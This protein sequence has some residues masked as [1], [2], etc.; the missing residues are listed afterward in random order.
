MARFVLICIS[1]MTKNVEHFF[2]LSNFVQPLKILQVKIFY[3]WTPFLI[4][5]FDSLESNFLNSLYILDISPLLD[6]RLLKMFPQ[7]VGCHFVQLTMSFALQKLY[8]YE[9]PF[10]NSSSYRISYKCSVQEIFPC[11]HVLKALPQFLF[12]YKWGCYEHSGTCVL[13]TC[14]GIL[15]VYAK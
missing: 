15:R 3:F 5:L 12:Y 8:I 4:G 1:L 14:W 9:F 7:F 6:V 13:I 10:V 11:A 2:R